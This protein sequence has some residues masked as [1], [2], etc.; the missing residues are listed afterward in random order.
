[1]SSEDIG[2]IIISVPW[3][4]ILSSTILSIP[5]LGC[6]GYHPT[7]LPSNRGRHPIIWTIALG[8]DKTASTFFKMDSSADSGPILSQKIIQLEKG[9]NAS[10]LYSI[11]TENAI[12][13][14]KKIIDTLDQGDIKFNAQPKEAN[15][16]RLRNEEDGKID[17]RMTADAIQCLVNSLS[18]PY[19][20]AH[21]IYGQEN[22]KIWECENMKM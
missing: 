7:C 9:T 17:W 5:R 1:M 10:K 20:G 8:L 2:P 22:V 12:K 16:W 18:H 13:Q 3:S 14:V 4:K 11:L 19:L 15:S 6:I 21:C